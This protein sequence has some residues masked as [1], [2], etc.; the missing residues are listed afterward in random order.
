MRIALLM[1]MCLRSVMVSTPWIV[2]VPSSRPGKFV[3][4]FTSLEL[5]RLHTAMLDRPSSSA[6]TMEVQGPDTK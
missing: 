3:Q 2:E 6:A 5:C 1:Q 4:F